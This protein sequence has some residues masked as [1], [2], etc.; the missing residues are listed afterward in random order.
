MPT[1]SICDAVDVNVYTYAKIPD[2]KPVN[3]SGKAIENKLCEQVP[4]NL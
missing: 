1:Q 3:Q 2:T 4:R